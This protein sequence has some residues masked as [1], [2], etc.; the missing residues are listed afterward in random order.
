[1]KERI[2]RIVALLLGCFF[3]SGACVLAQPYPNKPIRIIVP[4]G[5][6]GTTDIIA[7]SMAKKLTEQLGISVQVENKNGGS[8]IVGSQ[9]VAKAAPDGYTLLMAGSPHAINPSLRKEMPYDAVKS[10]E[11]VSLIGTVPMVLVVHPSLPVKTFQEFVAYG[12]KN[13]D[14]L[15][16]G[17]VPGSG[18]HMATESLKFAAEVPLMPVPYQSDAPMVVDLLGG[19]TNCVVLISTQGISYIRE[20][21]LIALAATS[22]ERL[23][24][25]P[26]LPTLQELGLTGFLAGSWN[27]LFAPAGTPP[28]VG[29]LIAKQ[30]QLALKDPKII[31]QYE[32]IGITI[33]GTDPQGQAKFLASDI[34]RWRD[35][36][37]NANIPQQ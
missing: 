6:G 26:N 1:M 9:F 31:E 4:F 2:K 19:H 23:P 8:S 18:N 35:V 32:Q 25:L 14:A 37:K 36:I 10:F 22:Q 3:V 28:E 24:F 5:P 12:K 13:P 29:E 17:V 33:V 27:G 15:R 21:R 7:R 11:P 20:G 30:I 34:A 16:C